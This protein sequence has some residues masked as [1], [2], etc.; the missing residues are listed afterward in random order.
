MKIALAQISSIPGNINENLKK[1]LDFITRAKDAKIDLIVFPEL[2]LTGYEP[3]L[4]K[5]LAFSK[6]DDRLNLFED[7]S[8]KNN[9]SIALGLPLALGSKLHIAMAIFEPNK[10]IRFY[11]KQFLHP[12]ELHFFQPKSNSSIIKIQQKKI[13]IAICYEVLV[14][15][16][17]NNINSEKIDFFLASVAKHQIGMKKAENALK[18]IS[19]KYKIPALLVNSIGKADG[20]TCYGKSLALNKYAEKISCLNQEESLL[21]IN[22]E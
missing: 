6:S 16:H 17:L 10:E 9:I 13:K 20:M 3:T 5:S 1:H 21:I 18:M 4:A 15:A 19:E 11:F 22:L 7:F 12:D 14:E 2:S 8:S